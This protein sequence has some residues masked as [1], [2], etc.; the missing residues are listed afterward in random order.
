MCHRYG[1]IKHVRQFTNILKDEKEKTL[2]STHLGSQ[3][4]WNNVTVERK[5]DQHL[6]ALKP[7]G[8]IV[9]GV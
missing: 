5:V 2:L 9:A 6:E 3:Q 1:V 8:S 4:V 7:E